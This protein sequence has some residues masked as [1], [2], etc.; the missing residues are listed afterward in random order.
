MSYDS[1]PDVVG[2]LNIWKTFQH[3]NMDVWA[4]GMATLVK[5]DAFA[6]AMQSFLDSYLAT[7]APFRKVLDQY[8]GFWLSSLN[9]PSRDEVTRLEQR[10]IGSEV[11]IEGLY[12]KLDHLLQ[13]TYEQKT[14]VSSLVSTQSSDDGQIAA[15]VQGIDANI[16]QM[17]RMLQA[18]QVYSAQLDHVAHVQELVQALDAKIEY[19]ATQVQGIDTKAEA[20]DAKTEHIATQMQGVEAK[21]EYITTQV[22]GIDTKAEALDAKTEHI[23]TQMQGVEA[24]T[25]QVPQV[26]H[27]QTTILEH[28]KAAQDVGATQLAL[29]TQAMDEHRAHM[30]QTI[31][32]LQELV[33]RQP[34]AVRH[35]YSKTLDES[36]DQIV[37]M[38]Q[39]QATQATAVEETRQAKIDSLEARFHELDAR[40]EQILHLLQEQKLQPDVLASDQSN[41]I[42]ALEQRMQALDEKSVQVLE[43]IHTL[44]TTVQ[45]TGSSSTRTRRSR[46]TKKKVGG[47]ESSTEKANSDAS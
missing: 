36:I 2:P 21:T 19:I 40:T 4:Q 14:E 7:S 23:A 32:A 24:K 22:Q 3:V 46:S 33:E 12:G 35:T 41:K 18:L 42:A 6:E 28:I 30:L 17:L 43:A 45:S 47:E 27:E 34:E 39:S 31:Q 11:R 29:H 13:M 26:L 9:M 38:I 8:M 10:I 16:D 5:T 25:E 20:L 44:Q 1:D 15:H 37:Q